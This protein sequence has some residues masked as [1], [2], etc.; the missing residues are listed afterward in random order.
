VVIAV[1][2]FAF[3]AF[4][5]LSAY[6]P[7]LR[8]GADGGAHA[9]SRSAVGFS[10]LV[11]LLESQGVPAQVSRIEQV[12][13]ATGLIVLTPSVD[14]D[15]GQIRRRIRDQGPPVLVVLPKWITK[16]DPRK[17]GWVLLSGRLED[18]VPIW[19]RKWVG[20]GEFRTSRG[21]L[22]EQAVVLHT[23]RPGTAAV[24][25]GSIRSLQT[26]VA[27]ASGAIEPMLSTRE[28][29]VLGQLRGG[30]RTIYVLSDPDLLN[31]HGLAELQT[32]RAALAIMEDTR[33]GAYPVVLDVSLNGLASGRNLLKLA[34]SP[35]FLAA[36]LCAVAAAA[37]AGWQAAVRFGPRMRTGRAVAL[38]SEALTENAAALIRMSGREHRMAAR[39]AALF[40]AR[41][42]RAVSAPADGTAAYLDGL[43]RRRPG[44]ARWSELQAQAG[45]AKTREALLDAARRIHAWRREVVSGG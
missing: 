42:A 17:P 10:A 36:T 34:L 7:D 25:A 32:A 1:G 45:A 18:Q 9:L 37:L 41:A 12:P 16:P 5:V 23:G 35:P 6:A 19:A 2:V 40:E 28:G 8:R 31:N 33:T 21:D 11:R 4:F 20:P 15:P 30:D 13:E 3:A 22:H 27:S 38:G 26:I 44:L 39:Y 24:P 29:V 43:G 14:S